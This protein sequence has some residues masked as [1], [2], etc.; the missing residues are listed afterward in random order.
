MGFT[1]PIGFQPGSSVWFEKT[2]GPLGKVLPVPGWRPMKQLAV[3]VH[4]LR[5]GGLLDDWSVEGV[6]SLVFVKMPSLGST[7]PNTSSQHNQSGLI[8]ELLT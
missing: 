2:Q 7:D 3:R 6:L 4:F 5:C 8:D 1:L